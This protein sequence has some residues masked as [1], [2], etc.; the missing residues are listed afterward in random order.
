MLRR[1]RRG[2]RVVLVLTRYSR[3]QGWKGGGERARE[4]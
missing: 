3:E 1:R 2:R 4:D